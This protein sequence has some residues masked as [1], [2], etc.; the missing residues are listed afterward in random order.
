MVSS[1]VPTLNEFYDALE[2]VRAIAV[3]TPVLESHWLSELTG[4]PVWFKCE[5]LQ[6]TGAYKLRGAYNL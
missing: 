1:K 3:K 6:R 4:Q 5:N 2:N